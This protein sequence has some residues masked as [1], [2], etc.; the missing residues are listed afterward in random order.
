MMSVPSAPRI[1]IVAMTGDRVIGD[2]GRMPWN[3]PE[4]LKLFRLQT[5]GHT[6]IMGRRTYLSIGVP[7]SDRRTI[8]V[9]RRLRP[10]PGVA[11]CPN[12]QQALNLAESYRNAVFFAGGVEIYREALALA[13]YLSIS[14]ISEP[15]SGDTFFPEFDLRAWQVVRQRDYGRFLHVVYRHR[16]REGRY[17]SGLCPE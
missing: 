11:V 15:C 17:W 6:L 9:S 13:D 3:I 7:L 8:V 4:E 2:A 16:D 12:L 5:R 1:I 10:A 14:W